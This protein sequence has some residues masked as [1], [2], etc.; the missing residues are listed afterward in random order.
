MSK[1]TKDS[2]YK[3]SQYRRIPDDEY[4]F[5]DDYEDSEFDEFSDY[6]DPPRKKKSPLVLILLIL[7]ILALAAA[8]AFIVL[9]RE[10]LPVNLDFFSFNKP[11]TTEIVSSAPPVVTPAPT[12]IPTPIPTPAPTPIPT[13][14]PTPDL[15]PLCT[16]VIYTSDVG[17]SERY[18]ERIHNIKTAMEKLDGIVLAPGDRFSFNTVCGPY[19]EENGYIESHVYYDSYPSAE[20]IT[21]VGGGVSE[22]ASHVYR[23]AIYTNLEIGEHYNHRHRFNNIQMGEDAYVGPSQ[24]E[25][26]TLNTDGSLSDLVFVN[27]LDQPVKFACSIDEEN[28]RIQ[29]DVL[30]S[31]PL[32]YRVFL[33]TDLTS[34]YHTMY[35]STCIGFQVR[36]ERNLF[37]RYSNY[38]SSN[39]LNTDRDGDGHIDWDRYDLYQEQILLH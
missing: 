16:D 28:L 22:L 21:Y 30:S 23:C 5:E 1:K 32:D 19:T 24:K 11:Q 39:S 26:G 15:S 29:V 17:Y 9:Q 6:Y 10:S 18:P 34:I 13:P 25:D 20:N 12:P 4:E 8:T 27:S 3:D 31:A 14:E 36:P 35:T 2:A 7:A 37:D 33:K 38:I